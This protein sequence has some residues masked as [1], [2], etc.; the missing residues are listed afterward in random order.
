[1]VYPHQWCRQF[2]VLEPYALG[3]SILTWWVIVSQCAGCC[4]YLFTCSIEAVLSFLQHMFKQGHTFSTLKEYLAAISP[5]RTGWSGRSQGAHPLA[6]RLRYEASTPT[7]LYVGPPMEFCAGASVK[8]LTASLVNSAGMQLITRVTRVILCPN[9]FYMPKVLTASIRS[10]VINLA[11]LDHILQSEP[12]LKS[13]Y[14]IAWIYRMHPLIAKDE[15]TFCMFRR[16][17]RVRALSIQRLALWMVEAIYL[18]YDA[19]R[20]QPSE[21]STRT[22]AATCSVWIAVS[23]QDMYQLTSWASGNTFHRF[24]SLDVTSM[25]VACSVLSTVNSVW[26]HSICVHSLLGFDWRGFSKIGTPKGDIQL[27]AISCSP[28]ENQFCGITRQSN[29]VFLANSFM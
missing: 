18:A 1:M 15:T 6:T 8:D 2:K 3:F 24:Y 22:V 10:Q 26:S 19:A 25:P 16:Q 14:S 4:H 13:C 11:A 17:A 28:S 27:G 5:C 7:S 9:P 23:F 12:E 21:G 29:E 20:V